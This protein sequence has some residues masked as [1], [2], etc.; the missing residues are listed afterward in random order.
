MLLNSTCSWFQQWSSACLRALL[1]WWCCVHEPCDDTR[2]V[3]CPPCRLRDTSS[4]CLILLPSCSI[5]ISVSSLDTLSEYSFTFD[6]NSASF[7]TFSNCFFLYSLSSLF[8]PSDNNRFFWGDIDPRHLL[9]LF[10]SP[11]RINILF[12]FFYCSAHYFCSSMDCS[13]LL[14]LSL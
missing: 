7:S 12:P 1:L 8:G 3:H 13:F 6:Q 9:Y 11:S 4:G 10:F 2:S 14:V 5:S